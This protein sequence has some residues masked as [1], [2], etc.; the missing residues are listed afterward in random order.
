MVEILVEYENMMPTV[1]GLKNELDSFGKLYNCNFTFKRSRRITGKDIALK[2]IIISIRA[3][4]NL[5]VKIAQMCKQLKKKYFVFYDDDLMNLPHDMM[6]D[7]RFRVRCTQK[8]LSEYT[9]LIITT[10]RNIGEKF[11]TYTPNKQFV[12]KDSAVDPTGLVA[13]QT[14]NG[15]KIKILYAA[16]SAHVELF[17]SFILPVLPR[18]IEKYSKDISLNF[19]GVRPDLSKFMNNIEIN[20]VDYIPYNEYRKFVR[21]QN[22][23]IGLAPIHTDDFSRCKYFNKFFE[24]SLIGA[25]G[26]YT[27]AEPYTFIVQDKINGF[28]AENNQQSWYEAISTAIENENQRIKCVE[29]AQNLLSCNFNQKIVFE[30]LASDVPDLI[31]FKAPPC[32]KVPSLLSAKIQYTVFCFA[33]TC[34][35]IMFY[36]K[37]GG[38]KRV[39]KQVITHVKEKLIERKALK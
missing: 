33:D 24:Y 10:N 5:S 20:Y 2:D 13:P 25:V 19:I 7:N 31:S 38:F 27:K 21:S 23:D 29:E 22:Y 34:L 39:Y 11:A 9:D 14:A 3:S 4:S 18:I 6:P 26:V 16:S 36:L 1:S 35:K 17:N 30:R 28:L 8:L 32:N 15:R 12:I 37:K